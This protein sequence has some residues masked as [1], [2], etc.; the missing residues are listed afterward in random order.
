MSRHNPKLY[1]EHNTAEIHAEL[2]LHGMTY[3]TPSVMSDAFRFGWIAAKQSHTINDLL[4]E[5]GRVLELDLSN[6]HEVRAIITRLKEHPNTPTDNESA[7]ISD[8][9]D[10]LD[11]ASG[12]R[13]YYNSVEACL[14]DVEETSAFLREKHKSQAAEIERLNARVAELEHGE[15]LEVLTN[16]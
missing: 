4:Y 2:A 12:W 15:K 9:F 5:L 11:C 1:P 16:E 7:L 3:K 14:A 13:G 8:A 6:A 10:V